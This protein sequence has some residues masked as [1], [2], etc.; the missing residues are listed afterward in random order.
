MKTEQHLEKKRR[1]VILK[2]KEGL[3]KEGYKTSWRDP[4]LAWLQGMSLDQGKTEGEI[5]DTLHIY[6]PPV[7]KIVPFDFTAACVRIDLD[8]FFFRYRSII[9][10]N[11]RMLLMPIP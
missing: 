6:D 3:E 8:H 4:F 7:P 11:W 5:A 1:K 9:A 2:I 10:K